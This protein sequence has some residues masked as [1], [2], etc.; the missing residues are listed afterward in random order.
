[1]TRIS[2][3]LLIE[4]GFAPS[5]YVLDLNHA[6][7]VPHGVELP[8][9]WN[10]PSRL[11]R[12]PI[13]VGEADKDGMRAIGLMHPLLGDHPF[14]RSV[15]AGL[16][17]ALNPGGA[18]NGCLV[19]KQANARWWHAVDLVLAGEWCTLIETR[20]F[21]TV[22]DIAGAV[23]FGLSHS[24]QDERA[25]CI[26]IA[27]ARELMRV[28]EVEEPLNR[29]E[30]LLALE[31]PRSMTTDRGGERWPINARGHMTANERAWGRIHGIE[32]GWFGYD[33]S[34]SLEWTAAGRDRY[35]A[36]DAATV[37]DSVTGQMGFAF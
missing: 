4:L 12:F 31:A 9:R 10:L 6:L 7:T 11:F 26:S 36:G 16:G 15:E 33:R 35:A 25:G 23:E 21:T 29:A 3:A 22:E 37:T 28:I 17:L 8:P 32:G 5:T 27:A 1:M 2:D 20:R 19:S 14:V 30:A 34:G 24:P 13:E 18:P